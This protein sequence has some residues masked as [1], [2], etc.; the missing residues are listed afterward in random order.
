MDE[1]QAAFLS[2]KL[3]YLNEENKMRS[4]IANK[5]LSELNCNLIE[6]PKKPNNVKEHV[7]HLF[8]IQCKK[9]DKLQNYLRE[10]SIETIIHYPIPPHK[11][12]AY[13]DF[14]NLDLPIT[15]ELSNE[16]L[17]LPISCIYN[18]KDLIYVIEK[19]N[20]FK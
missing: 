2:V 18:E 16:V 15:E 17:S 10:N 7:W 9:R 19:I 5:Y 3:K 6:L 14:Q 8:V 12:K 13:Y 1:L 20:S 11:Q 4:L